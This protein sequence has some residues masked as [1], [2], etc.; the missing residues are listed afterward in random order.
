MKKMLQE[1][2]GRSK[3]DFGFNMLGRRCQQYF[4]VET[5]NTSWICESPVLYER[6]GLWH[7]SVNHLKKTIGMDETA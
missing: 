7:K 6:S 1:G 4:Q 2:Q 5:L 3:S